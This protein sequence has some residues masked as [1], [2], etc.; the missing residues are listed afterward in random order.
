AIERVPSLKPQD[1]DEI[2]YGNVLSAKLTSNPSVSDKIPPANAPSMPASANPPS[3]LPSTKSAPRAPNPS[4]S[5]PK[6][7]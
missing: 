6:P 3:A 4:S 7:S 5:P 1:V 2:F